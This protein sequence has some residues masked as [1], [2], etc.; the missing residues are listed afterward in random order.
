MSLQLRILGS[1]GFRSWGEG[2]GPCDAAQIGKDTPIV[3]WGSP[4]GSASGAFL[5]PSCL[6]VELWAIGGDR[7]ISTKPRGIT[8]GKGPPRAGPDGPD[9]V[10]SSWRWGGAGAVA[11]FGVRG[12]PSRM[13]MCSSQVLCNLRSCLLPLSHPPSSATSSCGSILL[14]AGLSQPRGQLCLRSRLLGF[15]L[16]NQVL[17]LS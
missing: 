9:V 7:G 2:G 11:Q 16:Q 1:A 4:G 3:R 15:S 8:K 14:L 5:P 6:G 12:G 17:A 10:N 13:W